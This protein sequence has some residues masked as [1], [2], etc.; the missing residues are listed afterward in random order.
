MLNFCVKSFVYR[1]LRV[2]DNP[3]RGQMMVVL[4][5]NGCGLNL[6]MK[7]SL[8]AN[9]DT[10]PFVKCPREDVK[11]PTYNTRNILNYIDL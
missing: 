1:A 5:F 10:E 11:N 6:H 9:R 4:Q 7:S 3:L 8:Y 2:H